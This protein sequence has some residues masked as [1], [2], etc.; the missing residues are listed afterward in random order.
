MRLFK[1]KGRKYWIAEYY[2][3]NRRRVRKSTKKENKKEATQIATTWEFEASRPPEKLDTDCSFSEFLERYRKIQKRDHYKSYVS[4]TKYRISQLESYFGRYGDARDIDL[5]AIEEYI[6]I[7]LENV[8]EG[9][10]NKEVSTLRAILNRAYKEKRL[11]DRPEFPKLR[12]VPGRTRW[13]TPEEENRL[14]EAASGRARHLVPIIR[15]ACDT[16]GRLGEL[17]GLDWRDVDL[18]SG[19]ITFKSTKNGEDRSIRLCQR[20]TRVL[21]DLDP[22]E[23]GPVFTYG[24]KQI[25]Q[26][27]NSFKTARET[28]NLDDL[29]FHDLRH[30]FASRLVQAGVP[31]FHVMNALGHKSIEMVNRYAHL[32]PDYQ[33]QVVN[34]LDQV[35]R[36]SVPANWEGGEN[37]E[38]RK[39]RTHRSVSG[40][41]TLFGTLAEGLDEAEHR[42]QQVIEN[43]RKLAHPRGFEPLT[44]AFGGQRSIQLSYGCADSGQTKQGI[45]AFG[46]AGAN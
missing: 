3:C 30:T 12:K 13:L 26:L 44:S 41:G 32:A 11:R 39:V 24:G 10:I 22:K 20:A 5:M 18:S 45:V 43:K 37:T 28:A 7:R 19:R 6:D 46:Q 38:D 9:T 1:P 8:S 25:K 27:R 29:H 35:S 36:D 17:L 42:P 4:S 34:A 40:I 23:S 33:D 15:I 21:L 16:G 14:C 2:D 31:L